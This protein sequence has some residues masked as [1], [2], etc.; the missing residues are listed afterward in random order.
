VGGL[1]RAPHPPAAAREGRRRGAALDV[2][3]RSRDPGIQTALTTGVGD[4]ELASRD[5]QIDAH[6]HGEAGAAA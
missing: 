6:L 1:G 5:G 2:G 4:L 3:R